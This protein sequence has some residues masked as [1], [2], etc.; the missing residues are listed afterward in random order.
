MLNSIQS[1]TA[2]I[3]TGVPQGSILCPLLFTIYINDIIICSNKFKFIMY[4]D[5][6]TNAFDNI[7]DLLISIN[8]ELAKVNE[9]LQVKHQQ[10]KC[11]GVSYAPKTDTITK[12]KLISNQY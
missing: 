2:N 7:T 1:D 3:I 6:T 9:W 10:D 12:V 11:N 8:N 5:D 4:A